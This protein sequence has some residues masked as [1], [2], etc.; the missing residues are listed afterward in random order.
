[1]IYDV[2]EQLICDVPGD[3]RRMIQVVPEQ[4]I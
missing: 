1:M 3:F 4:L 2:P